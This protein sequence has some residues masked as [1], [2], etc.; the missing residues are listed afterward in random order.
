MTARMRRIA[1][2]WEQVKK[3]FAGHR[4]I[5]VTPVGGEPPEKYHVIYFVN[6]IYLLPDGTIETLGR[7]EVDIT[8]HADYPRYK[9]ICRIT[10]PIWHPNFKDGQI[11]IGDIWGAGE[12]L[13]DIIVNIGDMI[14]YKSWNSY[15]PLSAEAAKWAMENKHLFPVG[16]VDLYAADYTC[17]KDQV[18]IDLFDDNGH[19]TEENPPAVNE[20]PTDETKAHLS[21][22]AIIPVKK[23]DEN[24]FEISAEELDGIEFVPTVQRMHTVSHGGMVMDKKVN[25]KTVL[26]KGILW[27][28]I[29]AILG[30]GI[31]ELVDIKEAHVAPAMGYSILVD[32][33]EYR[34]EAY[35]LT[36][37]MSFNT[38]MISL[39]A[40]NAR[41]RT[42]R[43]AG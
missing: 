4:N 20:I 41:C 21:I 22:P 29:G 32:Y 11:C 26:V 15:S 31:S 25:F 5:I 8:L 16:T 23:P 7:H 42:T 40:A 13:S 3:D 19:S 14:Q 33:F 1:S 30:F 28:V 17:A 2:D 39:F 36:A 6:G 10:T 34:D 43:I 24:D 18:E 37:N 38:A 35:A 9:P 27:A 12:S